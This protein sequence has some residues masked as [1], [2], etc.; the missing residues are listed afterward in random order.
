MPTLKIKGFIPVDHLSDFPQIGPSLLQSYRVGQTIDE[1]VVWSSSKLQTVLTLKRSIINAAAE[2]RFPKSAQEVE[3]GDVY[4]CVSM[5]HQSFGVFAKLLCP[6]S[7]CDVLFPKSKMP[8]ALYAAAKKDTLQHLTLEGK[9]ISV[10]QE[11]KKISLS[12]LDAD[13]PLCSDQVLD[14]YFKDVEKIRTAMLESPDEK[15]KHLAGL[16]FGDSVIA[17]LSSE[18]D[19]AADIEFEL[20]HGLKGVVPAYHHAQKAFKKNDL[21]AGCVLYSDLIQQ[22]VYVTTRDD[23][24]AHIASMETLA[25]KGCKLKATILLHQD[26]FSLVSVQGKV[27]DIAYVSNVRNFNDAVAL[28]T[29]PYPVGEEVVVMITTTACGKVATYHKPPKAWAVA[30]PQKSKRANATQQD[31]PA[32]KKAKTAESAPAAKVEPSA[33]KPKAKDRKEESTASAK[34]AEKSKKKKEKAAKINPIE[35]VPAAKSVE[36]K[37]K[38]P[39]PSRPI[40]DEAANVEDVSPPKKI[41]AATSV[42]KKSPFEL[43]RLSVNAAFKWDDDTVAPAPT[44]PDSSDSEDEDAQPEKAVVK[45]RRER[46]RQKL[47]E[48][49]LEEAKLSQIEESLNDPDRTPVSADDFDRLVLASPN[50]SILW[51]QYMAFHLENAEFEKARTVAQ[52]ALKVIS[53]REEQEKFNVWIAWLNLE[54][55][56]GTTESYDEAFQVLFVSQERK[57]KVNLVFFF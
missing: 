55:M 6:P 8:E 35:T 17:R 43:P 31:G 49:R 23:V 34:P 22:K 56:Y 44:I 26:Y 57:E 28:R 36:G 13:V 12:A 37:T 3:E 52:R 32:K 50:S 38:A 9:V 46:A 15:L 25:P 19:P 1:A 18:F 54:H 40:V 11:Q 24:L 47:E 4:P 2:T 29:P 27:P 10:D 41:R 5:R 14:A 51:L 7:Q 21:I 39:T 42:A 33:A 53:F 16:K 30:K 48:A 20:P 45:D